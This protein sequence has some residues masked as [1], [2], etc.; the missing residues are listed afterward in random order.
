MPL[1]TRTTFQPPMP[2]EEAGHFF[3]IDETEKNTVMQNYNWFRYEGIGFDAYPVA[4]SGNG[5]EEAVHR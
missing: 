5:V 3:T 2:L 1:E 4:Q